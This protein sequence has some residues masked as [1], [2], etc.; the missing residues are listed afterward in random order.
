MESLFILCISGPSDYKKYSSSSPISQRSP[1]YDKKLFPTSSTQSPS[2]Q[3]LA[4]FRIGPLS[5]SL[6]ST[7]EDRA[8]NGSGGTGHYSTERKVSPYADLLG[9]SSTSKAV[10]DR[11]DAFDRNHNISENSYFRR[12]LLNDEQWGLTSPHSKTQSSPRDTKSNQSA[13]STSPYKSTHHYRPSATE[14]SKSFPLDNSASKSK[15]SLRSTGIADNEAKITVTESSPRQAQSQQ[16]SVFNYGGGE[17]G[18]SRSHLH[19]LMNH[20]L[21]TAHSATERH[22]EEVNKR[23]ANIKKSRKKITVNLQGTRYEVG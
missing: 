9:R 1:S 23:K 5:S 6:D 20:N 17:K 10:P 14:T 4:D 2:A 7:G 3:R 21:M 13:L 12:S 18:A 22:E 8:S 11:D 15:N 19:M 16:L